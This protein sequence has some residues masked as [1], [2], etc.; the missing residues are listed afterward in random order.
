[1]TTQTTEAR[2]AAR[3]AQLAKQ[4]AERLDPLDYPR[5]WTMRQV[6]AYEVE[7]AQVDQQIASLDHA[8]ARLAAIDVEPNQ[9]WRDFLTEAR[10]TL[11]DELFTIKSPIRDR[12][13]KRQSDDLTFSIRLIDFGLA[14]ASKA[15]PI[16]TLAPTRIGQLMSAAGYAVAVPD[17]H[18]PSGW[19][20]S[21]P[22]VEARIKQLTEQRAEAL[23]ALA[24]ALMDDEARQQREAEQ[25][26]LRSMRI[27]HSAD[28]RTLV[29]VKADGSELPVSEM[30]EIERRAFERMQAARRREV[31]SV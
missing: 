4:R 29:A 18:G 22:E 3:R 1:M 17:L 24:D 16:V 2:I 15:M 23:R 6:R 20:G 25:A 27:R 14:K 11:C 28:G 26:A 10:Q 19:R 9:R 5:V 7:T 12:E 30:S 31:V 13:L 8:V 21:V